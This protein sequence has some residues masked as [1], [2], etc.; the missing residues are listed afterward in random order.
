ME[1]LN[2]GV[3]QGS[4]TPALDFIYFSL[5][6]HLSELCDS[7]LISGMADFSFLE[8]ANTMHTYRVPPIQV[9]T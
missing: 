5:L 1:P 4:T 3:A 7:R 2:G 6:C 9:P 8:F